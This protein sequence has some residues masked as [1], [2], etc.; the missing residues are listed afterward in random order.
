MIENSPHIKVGH[1]TG[2]PTETADLNTWEHMKSGPTAREP[3]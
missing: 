1:M 3:A 2:E